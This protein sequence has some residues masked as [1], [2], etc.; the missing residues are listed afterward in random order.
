[1]DIEDYPLTSGQFAVSIAS[2]IIGFAKISGMKLKSEEIQIKNEGGSDI[3]IFVPDQRKN[4]N[5]L[6]L[7]KGVIW[8]SKTKDGKSD[9]I[10]LAGT[11]LWDLILI[12][13]GRDRTVK[14]A[15][16]ANYA[17]VK[18]ISLSDLNASSPETLIESMIVGYDILKPLDSKKMSELSS[19]QGTKAGS[20]TAAVNQNLITD[21]KKSE[22][23]SKTKTW[24]NKE[25][26]KSN[27]L[28]KQE[29]LFPQELSNPN[30]TAAV[31]KNKQVEQNK[32][33]QKSNEIFQNELKRKQKEDKVIFE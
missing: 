25:V 31:Q 28:E 3:P 24:N 27:S 33:K 8:N 26:Q 22:S 18:E 23:N 1:M 32:E 29:N 15:Y 11:A 4:M 21:A 12:I 14:R 30:I 19:S 9:L 17:V 6:T 7:E 16:C 10:S 20:K 13:Y 2:K 5:T